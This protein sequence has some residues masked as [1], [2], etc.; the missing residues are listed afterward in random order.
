MLYLDANTQLHSK[1]VQGHSCVKA[2]QAWF[3]ASGV[4]KQ[5]ANCTS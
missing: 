2:K 1:M 3:Q 4:H 5:K